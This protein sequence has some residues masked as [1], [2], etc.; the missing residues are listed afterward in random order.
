MPASPNLLVVGAREAEHGT[1]SLRSRS[2]EDLGV[3][4]LDRVLADLGHETQSRAVALTV[5]RS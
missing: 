1:V 2:G 3:L 4:P 5:G